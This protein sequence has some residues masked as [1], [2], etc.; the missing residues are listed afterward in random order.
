MKEYLDMGVKEVIDRFPG[1]AEI[2]ED[3][4]I[5]CVPCS[6]G[7]CALKDVV[8]IHDSS[9]EEEAKIMRRIADVIFPGQKVEIPIIDRPENKTPTR[10]EFSPPLRILVDEHKLIKRL[11]AMIPAIASKLDVNTEDDKILIRK[12][13]DFIRSYADKFHH[14][15]EEDI[16][17][18]YFDESADIIQVMLG[19]HIEGRNHIKLMLEGLEEEDQNKVVSHLTAYGELLQQHIQKEDEI[20]Y[21]WMDRK[22]ST[23]QVGTMYSKFFEVESRFGENPMKYREFIENLE[24]IF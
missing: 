16:L 9:P 13:A 5:G 18:K 22:L 24:E 3:Y 12:C 8:D 11:L 10:N 7:T 20:L 19:D 6:L 23:N 14:A 4:N 15:K 1:V 17:F 2:L 21:P